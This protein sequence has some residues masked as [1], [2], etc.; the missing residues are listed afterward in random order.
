MVRQVDKMKLIRRFHDILCP[1]VRKVVE[2]T[3]KLVA[4]YVVKA[5]IYEQFE[6]S[7][8]YQEHEQFLVDLPGGSCSCRSWDLHKIHCAHVM[9]FI[10]YM[11]H[12]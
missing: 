5:P 7:M 10:Y 2:G 12:G 11:N 8:S 6:V 1:N 9:T 3:K 4:K